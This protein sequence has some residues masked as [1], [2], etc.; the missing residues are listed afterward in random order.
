MGH[1]DGDD[2]RDVAISRDIYRPWDRRVFA[3]DQ[4]IGP[5]IPPPE[6][7]QQDFHL[8][9]QGCVDTSNGNR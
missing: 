1:Q 2:A 5:G 7:L 6:T 9:L 4:A 3:R 8:S